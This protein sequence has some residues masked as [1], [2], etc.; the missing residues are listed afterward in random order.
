MDEDLFEQV[1]DDERKKFVCKFPSCGKFFRYK[2][3]IVRHAATHSESRP[4]ICQYD[5]CY[6]AF[7]RND[8]LENHIR[9]SHTKETPFVCPVSDCGAKFTTHGSFRYHVLKHNKQ[10]EIPEHELEEE[11]TYKQ[12]KLTP[13]INNPFAYSGKILKTEPEAQHLVE[14]AMTAE[15]Y[16]PAP[17][18][19]SSIK[20]E[21]VDDEV[22]NDE[23]EED[24]QE[25]SKEKVPDLAQENH[26]LKERLASSE[27]TIE[28]MQRQMNEM[29]N[30]LAVYRSQF[31]FVGFANYND[32]SQST[33]SDF[34]QKQEPAVEM[35]NYTE[36]KNLPSPSANLF[37]AH[38][39]SIDFLSF[40]Q[41]MTNFDF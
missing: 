35:I 25:I 1:S 14:K 29:M 8:A 31:D 33:P 37:I 36:V 13:S 3:E 34:T 27:K 6:K 11:S 20:W 9:S 5:N 10:H 15:F 23:E 4:F 7:K 41:D 22:E 30:E 26:H 18:F 2:S 38:N 21:M 16:V 39:N 40:S 12:I 28:N 32:Q 24:N 17:R 19:A